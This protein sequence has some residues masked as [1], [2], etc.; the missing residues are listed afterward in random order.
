M[1]F[2]HKY[3]TVRNSPKKWSWDND[4]LGAEEKA[5]LLLDASCP[6]PH[7]KT[8]EPQRILDL[9]FR[10]D[11]CGG[12]GKTG[13]G[14]EEPTW[15]WFACLGPCTCPIDHLSAAHT[16]EPG[17][18][19]LGDKMGLWWAWGSLWTSQIPQFLPCQVWFQNPGW[20]RARG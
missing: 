20:P 13:A 17:E 7:L 15:P 12:D 6:K 1:P 4:T 3:K 5:N 10:W 2:S 16:P 18:Q 9:G 14:E 8:T 19:L 11:Q